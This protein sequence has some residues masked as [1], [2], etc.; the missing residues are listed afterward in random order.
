MKPTPH[1]SCMGLPMEMAELILSELKSLN[2]KLDDL[3]ADTK[4][5]LS[6]LEAQIITDADARLTQLET[7]MHPL[8]GNGQPGRCSQ[9][10]AWGQEAERKMDSRVKELEQWRIG[11]SWWVAGATTIATIVGAAIGGV[12]TWAFEY[13]KIHKG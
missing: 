5:R 6:T 12:I 2:T 13:F 1:E 9:Q 4:Q 8:V 3:S 7:Q 11:L 10:L